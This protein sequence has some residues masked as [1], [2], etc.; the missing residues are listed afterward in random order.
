MLASRIESLY[1]TKVQER[2]ISKPCA[3][4]WNSLYFTITSILRKR[5]AVYLAAR[6]YV[7]DASIPPN[8][9]DLAIVD[10][11]ANENF[12]SQL[13]EGERV[14]RPLA[15]ASLVMQK[16]SATLADVFYMFVSLYS[17]FEEIDDVASRIASQRRLALRFHRVPQCYLL[18]AFCLS[19]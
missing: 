1:G 7:V 8:K 12:F 5:S 17:S 16:E 15:Y 10:I 11:I 18:L 14:L 13:L 2:T 3:T 6:D 4:R 9:K 19:P